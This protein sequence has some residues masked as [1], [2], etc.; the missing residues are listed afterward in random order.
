[1]AWTPI[2]RVRHPEIDDL[3]PQ[4]GELRVR[5]FLSQIPPYEWAQRF[6][7][8]EGV[9]IPPPLSVDA[10][11]LSLQEVRFRAPEGELERY[12]KHI[13]ERIAAA[14]KHYEREILPAEQERERRRLQQEEERERRLEEARRRAE[15]L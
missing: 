7:H 11:Q 9:G 6:S 13:D 1:M 5:M 14:N 15:E 8:P 12:V 3:D 4:T 2:E 10:P